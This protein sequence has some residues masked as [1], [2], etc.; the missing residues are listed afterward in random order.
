MTRWEYVEITWNPAGVQLFPAEKLDREEIKAWL[1]KNFP[2][3]PGATVEEIK[4]KDRAAWCRIHRLG[5]LDFVVV[6]EF[7]QYLGSEGWEAL[8]STQLVSTGGALDL[9]SGVVW[10]KRPLSG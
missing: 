9:H 1:A 6:R 3:L 7:I 8:D 5:G 10:F 2:E 4:H